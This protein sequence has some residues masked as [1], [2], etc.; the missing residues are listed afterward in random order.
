V[1]AEDGMIW[2]MGRACM[3]VR[4]GQTTGGREGETHMSLRGRISRASATTGSSKVTWT[5][6]S[7]FL[8]LLGVVA[9]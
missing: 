3:R 2:L 5:V 8:L 1:Q 6:T 4:R 7:T 9:V